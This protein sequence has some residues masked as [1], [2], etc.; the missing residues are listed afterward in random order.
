VDCPADAAPRAAYFFFILVNAMLYLRPAEIIAD[1]AEVPVYYYAILPC[2][3]CA[4]AP[5]LRKLTDEV[6]RHSPITLCVGLLLFGVVASHLAHLFLWGA[7]TS[8]FDYLKVLLYYLLLITIIDSAERLRSFLRW[9][10]L[11]NACAAVLALLQYHGVID[12]AALTALAQ[13]TT[14][15]TTG[16]IYI[17]P[18]LQGTGM[19]NDPNDLCVTLSVAFLVAL[20]F[21]FDPETPSRL[22]WLPLLTLSEDTAQDRLQLWSMGLDLFRQEPLFG[23]GVG[24]YEEQVGMVAHNSFVHCFTELGLVGGAWFLGAFLAAGRALY[25]INQDPET[26]A[27]DRLERLKPYLLAI[28]TAYAA[29]I[30]TLSRS[31]QPTTYLVLGLANVFIGMTC[32]VQP[33]VEFC[34]NGRFVR[35]LAAVSVVFLIGI[36]VYVRPF[37]RWS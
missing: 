31:Y 10:V 23:I 17:V 30:M 1:W 8:G 22:V 21:C 37:V 24:Q 3:L 32:A 4:Y 34:F 27:D 16:E 36:Y 6:R 11:F 25:R 7:R 15:P 13:K 33:R 9:L 5:V 26:L 18:R 19:F 35:Q 29:G 2:L 14:D 28:V 20:Y 12:I